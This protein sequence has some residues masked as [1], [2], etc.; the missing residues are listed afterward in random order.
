M[1]DAIVACTPAIERTA[2]YDFDTLRAVNWVS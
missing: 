1:V 2:S